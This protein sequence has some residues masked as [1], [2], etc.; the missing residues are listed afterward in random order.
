MQLEAPMLDLYTAVRHAADSIYS[1]HIGIATPPSTG[2]PSH[3][4]NQIHYFALAIIDCKCL[5]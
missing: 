3:L 1:A 4:Y 2:L 5:V